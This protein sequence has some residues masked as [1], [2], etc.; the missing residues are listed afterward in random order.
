MRVAAANIV[1]LSPLNQT[2]GVGTSVANPPS[3]QV[4]DGSG[5]PVPGVA[6]TFNVTVGGGTIESN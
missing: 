1:A 3:V 4:T 2:A 5:N 6:V